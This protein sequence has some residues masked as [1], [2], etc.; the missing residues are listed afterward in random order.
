MTLYDHPHQEHTDQAPVTGHDHEALPP[1]TTI[2]DPARNAGPSSIN[3]VDTQPSFLRRHLREAGVFAVGV[4]AAAGGL[5]AF[6]KVSEGSDEQV[7][8]KNPVAP[9]VLP[10]QAPT[11]A[12]TRPKP[13]QAPTSTE[14]LPLLDRFAPGTQ[15]LVK[16]AD[17]Y[18]IDYR[19]APSKLSSYIVNSDKNQDLINYGQEVYNTIIEPAAKSNGKKLVPLALGECVFYSQ[20]ARPP[21]SSSDQKFYAVMVNPVKIEKGNKVTYYANDNGIEQLITTEK[22]PDGTMRTSFGV[23][24]FEVVQ[25]NK[26]LETNM[27]PIFSP[28]D[29]PAESIDTNVW[30]NTGSITYTQATNIRSSRAIAA[31]IVTVSGPPN[32]KLTS[33]QEEQLCSELLDKTNASSYRTR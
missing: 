9:S 29:Y 16:T 5:L 30:A 21:E 10:T 33:T 25:G 23:E 26:N 18:E 2:E 20:T 15:I 11:T 22:A 19:S 12:E 1:L 32:L 31:A 24:N 14:A 27:M 4:L 28:A 8:P 3:T 6:N 13:S 17:G 7:T